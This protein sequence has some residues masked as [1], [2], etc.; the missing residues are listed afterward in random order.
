MRAYILLLMVSLAGCDALGFRDDGEMRFDVKGERFTPETTIVAHLKNFSEKPAFVVASCAYSGMEKRV[1][2]EWIG[3]Y[4][5]R[6]ECAED[7][8]YTPVPPGD[9]LRK[10]ITSQSLNQI[11]DE[12]VGEY[13]FALRVSRDERSD[14]EWVRSESFVVEIE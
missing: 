12:P 6:V 13:R 1:E 9:S 7:V 8:F 3:L 5:T 2:E 10:E 4:Y 11:T 14:G